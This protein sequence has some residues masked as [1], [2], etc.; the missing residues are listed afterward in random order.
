MEISLGVQKFSKNNYHY[1]MNKI[2]GIEKILNKRNISIKKLTY[3]R[4]TYLKELNDISNGTVIMKI[5]EVGGSWVNILF[6]K[7]YYSQVNSDV[8]PLINN[9]NMLVSTIN[10]NID[11]EINSMYLSFGFNNY[12]KQVYIHNKTKNNLM[13]NYEIEFLNN[14]EEYLGFKEKSYV[15]QYEGVVTGI[16]G[17]IFSENENVIDSETFYVKI[18]G[19]NNLKRKYI[20]EDDYFEYSFITTLNN[21]LYENTIDIIE[22]ELELR[23]NFKT[24]EL[25]FYNSKGHSVGFL[26]DFELFLEVTNKK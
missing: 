3:M 8:I 10:Y 20:K 11:T 24:F 17:Q 6:K 2:N 25:C 21:N 15:I 16:I 12:E 4:G 9:T 19:N 13:I 1:T 7:N 26:K 5:R 14:F 23:E 22:Q 18:I